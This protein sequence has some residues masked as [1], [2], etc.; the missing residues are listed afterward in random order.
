M[1]L[2]N[3]PDKL[4]LPFAEAG[5]K[6]AIPVASQIGITPGAASLTDGFPPLTRT[7]LS[8]GGVPP[9]GIDMN[10]ILYEI[11]DVIR[12]ANA[13]GG[14]AYDGTFAADSNVGG[15]PKGAR[16]MRSDGLGYWLNTIENNT[17]D[18]EATGAAIAGWVPDFASGAS[19]ITMTS[20]NVTLTAAEYG[21]P[22]IVITGLLTA[23]LNLIFPAIP[24][25]WSVINATTGAFTLTCKTLSGGGVV[26]YA[27]LTNIT[28]DGTDVY[29]ESSRLSAPTGAGFVGWIRQ[30]TG[31]IGTTVAAKLGW[32]RPC[33]FEFASIALIS[34]IQSN[35]GAVNARAAIAAA[36]TAGPFV[37]YAGTYLVPT[38][39]TITNDCE[40][41]P[42]AKLSIASGAVVTFAKSVTAGMWQIFAGDGTVVLG[43]TTGKARPEWFGAGGGTGVDLPAIQKC[44]NACRTNGVTTLLGQN[45]Y[46]KAGDAGVLVYPDSPIDTEGNVFVYAV[47]QADGFVFS[48]G[49]YLGP[50]NRLP[51]L[52]GFAGEA[53]RLHGTSFCRVQCPS[54]CNGTG[55]GGSS[56]G[57]NFFTDATNPNCLDNKVEIFV[58]GPNMANAAV[59]SGAGPTTVLQGNIFKSN[60]IV[61]TLRGC[62]F[63]E[64]LAGTN[65]DGNVLEIDA[66]DP[67]GIAGAILVANAVVT[68]VPRL[69]VRVVSWIGGF[70]GAS[71]QWVTG[72]FDGLNLELRVAEALTSY[73]QM[74]V[75]G[76]GGKITLNTS[77]LSRQQLV[78]PATLTQDI[79]TFNSGAPITQVRFASSITIPA[80]GLLNNALLT[81]FLYSPYV[82]FISGSMSVQF[83]DGKGVVINRLDTTVNDYEILLEIRNNSGATLTA[84]TVVSF[85]IELG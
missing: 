46:G 10:G 16:V 66:I 2:S 17:T 85:Y 14:Y 28:C 22:V 39:L 65:W 41:L 71:A 9:S 36:D 49:T 29:S 42:G 59:F 55:P 35:T 69:T 20:A 53:I 24:F 57:V 11:T 82:Q 74:Q 26:A 60:F 51:T 33:P 81:T 78:T 3:S 31:A 73:S 68:S 58:V 40:F 13:G 63:Y 48:P 67:A 7:P 54:V 70:S 77:G 75:I 18:P 21:K 72:N 32:T 47:S 83:T 19:S 12:W 80:G 45:Y 64:T 61:S 6:R 76:T 5:G 27:G 44:I 52:S 4:V 15:Y 50:E 79:S 23:N 56:V 43:K 84:G 25:N 8:A 1:Q 30:A 38:S 34:D 37:F 62:L